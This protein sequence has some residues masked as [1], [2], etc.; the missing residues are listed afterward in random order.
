VLPHDPWRELALVLVVTCAYF[1]TRGLIRGR[2]S[3][4][5]LHARDI[6]AIEQTLHIEPEGVLQHLALAHPLALQAANLFYLG[7]HLPVLIAVAV[8]LYLRHP[9]AYRFY[10][11]A[12]AISALL[13]LA[14]YIALPVAPPRFLPGFVDTLKSAGIGLD[15]STVGLLYNP[16]AAMP[17][18]HVGWALLAGMALI[19]SARTRWLRAAG[20]ALPALMTLVVLVTGN[21]FLLDVLA[22]IGIA[23]LSLA[24]SWWGSSNRIGRQGLAA[25]LAT[26]RR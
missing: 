8:W 20:V 26:L 7:G 13:G 14:I 23:L 6:L 12:F 25:I 24:C 16:Y 10:R 22:G 3:D 18:L 17:S 9:A 15:G 19:T 21:H 5:L 11:N 4:A 2:A 1:L